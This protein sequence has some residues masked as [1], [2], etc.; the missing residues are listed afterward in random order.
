MSQVGIVGIMVENRADKAEKVQHII[1]MYGDAIF[2]RMGVP[3]PD[4]FAGIITVAMDG[5]EKRIKEFLQDL[6]KVG[7]VTANY[8]IVQNP[9]I[10]KVHC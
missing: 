10:D 9:A 3:S 2:A 6:E 7:G 8:C 4:R 5:D 1:T